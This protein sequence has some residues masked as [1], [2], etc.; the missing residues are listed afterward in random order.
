M[1]SE[2]AGET[3]CRPPKPLPASF[4]SGMQTSIN[5]QPVKGGSEQHNKREK[6][7]DYVRSELSHRNAYWESD[8]QSSRLALIKE[9][10][11]ASTGQRMQSKATPIR[12]GV[13]VVHDG[14]TMADLHRLAKAYEERF[15]I[16]TFQIALHKDEGHLNAKEWKAN[17][18]AHLVF[19]W[20]DDKGKT[21]KLNR[22]DMV[23]MQTLTAEVLG[24]E[25]G[26]SSDKTHLA[27]L[28]FK[29]EAE[30]HRLEALKDEVGVADN[31]REK[32]KEATEAS[33]KPV[34]ELIEENTRKSI[35]GSPKVDYEA[36]IDQ[37]KEQERNKAIVE[38]ANLS[39]EEYIKELKE[40][41]DSY[42]EEVSQ[43]K[44]DLLEK[45]LSHEKDLQQLD[46]EITRMVYTTPVL[47]QQE[48]LESFVRDIEEYHYDQRLQP[49][50]ERTGRISPSQMMRLWFDRAKISLGGI[51]ASVSE[52]GRLLLDGLRPHQLLDKLRG[53]AQEL[54]APSWRPGRNQEEPGS[55]GESQEASHR[56]SRKR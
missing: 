18:H 51:I 29:T 35:F 6:P 16:K 7:L 32:I 2:G 45:D 19:D 44:S 12:E 5:I 48:G 1:L 33:V 21:I 46:E 41:I 34:E 4:I 47:S 39:K 20:T 38:V 14:T 15:G 3:P 54:H 50:R 25:R 49:I 27:S 13:V 10:Y 40:R 37:I 8:T 42:A 11:H 53:V 31:F 23:A 17:L 24:M 36:V 9:L 22:A 55:Q 43:L 28:Q 52:Q 30:A 56:T 26:V